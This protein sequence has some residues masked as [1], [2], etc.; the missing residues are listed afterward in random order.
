MALAS[1]KGDEPV[2]PATISATRHREF[3]LAWV[4][5]D[6]RQPSA[7]GEDFGDFTK[8]A[9]C[10]IDADAAGRWTKKPYAEFEVV[11]WNRSRI[12]RPGQKFSPGIEKLTPSAARRMQMAAAQQQLSQGFDTSVPM[13]PTSTKDARTSSGGCLVIKA[14]GRPHWFPVGMR[15]MGQSRWHRSEYRASGIKEGAALRID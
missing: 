2:R 9:I 13:E 12:L 8:D 14:N 11:G 7:D 6:H 15:R 5:K 10:I 4:L 1:S 3:R